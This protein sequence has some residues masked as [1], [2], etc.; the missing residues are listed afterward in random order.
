VALSIRVHYVSLSCGE[1]VSGFLRRVV[2]SVDSLLC[3]KVTACDVVD[4]DERKRAHTA[5]SVLTWLLSTRRRKTRHNWS[6]CQ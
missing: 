1:D 3:V 4:K 6:L 5:F 2:E